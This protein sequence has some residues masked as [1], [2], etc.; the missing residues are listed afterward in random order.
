MASICPQASPHSTY[1]Y[2]IAGTSSLCLSPCLDH[3]AWPIIPPLLLNTPV[4]PPVPRPPPPQGLAHKT[5]FVLSAKHG[6]SPMLP[7]EYMPMAGSI[8]TDALAAA[9]IMASMAARGERGA[10]GAEKG[11]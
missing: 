1:Q 8:I 9:G 11:S 10:G 4:Y 7:S 3:R 2:I 6:Q 5:A